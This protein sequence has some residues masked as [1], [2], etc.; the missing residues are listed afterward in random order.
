MS[1]VANYASEAGNTA[2]DY[3]QARRRFLF[4]FPDL[5]GKGIHVRLYESMDEPR[6]G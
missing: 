5:S 3:D 4:I 1:M 6:C 2:R